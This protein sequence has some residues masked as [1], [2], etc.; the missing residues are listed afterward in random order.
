[1][2]CPYCGE[3]VTTVHI[4]VVRLSGNK[5]DFKNSIITTLM[6]SR[7]DACPHSQCKAEVAKISTKQV[8]LAESL[9][10]H[11]ERQLFL[12]RTH[13]LLSHFLIKF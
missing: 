9:V 8:L 13:N 5:S 2:S 3:F 12:E 10:I 7:L 4:P 11:L 6:G 1:M